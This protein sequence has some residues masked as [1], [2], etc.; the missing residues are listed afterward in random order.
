MPVK[1]DMEGVESSVA[2]GLIGTSAEFSAVASSSGWGRSLPSESRAAMAVFVSSVLAL[3]ITVP[4]GA[5][6]DVPAPF[7]G[8]IVGFVTIVIITIFDSLFD[9]PRGDISL[10]CL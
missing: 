1:V 2:V 4:I 3:T 5:A 8:N 10:C 9:D 6:V 7:V